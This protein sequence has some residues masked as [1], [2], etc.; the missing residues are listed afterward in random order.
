MVLEEKGWTLSVD[1]WHQVT[2]TRLGLVEEGRNGLCAS[3]EL[4]PL[5]P[6]LSAESLTG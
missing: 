3:P 5:L 6:R 4:S 1:T 2:V